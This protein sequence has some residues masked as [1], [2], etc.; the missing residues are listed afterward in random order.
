[1]LVF[2]ATTRR[3]RADAILHPKESLCVHRHSFLLFG[4]TP[5]T[6]GLLHIH[7]ETLVI[8]MASAQ[9][10]RLGGNLVLASILA[11]LSYVPFEMVAKGSLVFCALLFIV[12]PIPPTSRLLSVATVLVVAVLTRLHNQWK[13]V[14]DE[15]NGATILTTT[16][17]KDDD[18]QDEDEDSAPTPAL[19]AS[20]KKIN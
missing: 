7:H 16:T 2:F 13:A 15:D 18:K 8:I 17:P 4:I 3:R 20:N 5:Q 9:P 12:D 11:V 14:N 19:G 6:L 10:I 1:L